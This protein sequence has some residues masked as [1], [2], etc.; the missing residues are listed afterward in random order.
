MVHLSCVPAAK[1]TSMRRSTPPPRF[2][3][4]TLSNLGL[5]RLLQTARMQGDE[6]WLKFTRLE[7]AV[8]DEDWRV[9]S[10][11]VAEYLVRGSKDGGLSCSKLGG[12]LLKQPCDEREMALLL[13][14]SRLT[15]AFAYFLIPQPN[16]IVPGYTKEMHCVTWG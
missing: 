16:P 13:P 1:S 10:T 3:R 12:L 15:S 7:G 6:F 8:G 4:H 9:N 2:M 5:R 14:P 11:G